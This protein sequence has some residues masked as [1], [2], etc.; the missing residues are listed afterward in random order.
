MA[1]SS[2]VDFRSAAPKSALA[3]LGTTIYTDLG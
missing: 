1:F 2:E 3:D